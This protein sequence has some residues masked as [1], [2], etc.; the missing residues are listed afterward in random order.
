MDQQLLLDV[1]LGESVGDVVGHKD[2]ASEID[3]SLNLGISGCLIRE[4]IL[5]LEILHEELVVLDVV[6]EEEVSA[7][8][9][10]HPHEIK[11]HT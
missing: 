6:E 9:P 7:S 1:A 10:S 3:N 2:D 4:K 8:F 11:D 5:P